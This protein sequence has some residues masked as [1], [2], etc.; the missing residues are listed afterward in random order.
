MASL[1]HEIPSPDESTERMASR[2]AS[3]QAGWNGRIAASPQSELLAL[4]L[5]FLRAELAQ[6]STSPQTELFTSPTQKAS[7]SSTRDIASKEIEFSTGTV[8]TYLYYF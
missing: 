4:R 2:S 7:G 3:I 6:T 8:C 1:T 5:A